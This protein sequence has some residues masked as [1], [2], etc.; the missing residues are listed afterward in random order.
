M[1]TPIQATISTEERW[2]QG[3]DHDPRSEDLFNF[4]RKYD[5]IFNRSG[6]DLK[7]GGDGDIG[8]ELMYLMD[9]YFAARDSMP[10]GGRNG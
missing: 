9:E 10:E 1:Q 4:M 5:D 2:E 6:L 8:E 3:I 7:C